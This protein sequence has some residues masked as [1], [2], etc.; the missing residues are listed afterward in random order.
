MHWAKKILNKI[1]ILILIIFTFNNLQKNPST[2]IQ[3]QKPLLECMKTILRKLYAEIE[4]NVS[5]S[6]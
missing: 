5:D 6:F 2:A 4:K 3:T 1:N